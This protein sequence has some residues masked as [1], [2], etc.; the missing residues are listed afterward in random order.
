[1][2]F[3]DTV[4]DHASALQIMS[5][6]PEPVRVVAVMAR[7]VRPGESIIIFNHFAHE[8][9]Q[10]AALSWLERV[11]AP[12]A[13]RLWWHSDFSR[14]HVMGFPGLGLVEEVRRPPLGLMVLMRL[15][16]I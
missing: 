2:D 6:V 14:S 13:N 7:V 12:F 8:D 16:K 3:A 15:R 1:M 9:D 11:A 5:V 10:V 4:F